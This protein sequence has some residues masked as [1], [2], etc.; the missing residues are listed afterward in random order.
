ME[1]SKKTNEDHV[2]DELSFEALEV[3]TTTL[4][5]VQ[6]PQHYGTHKKEETRSKTKKKRTVDKLSLIAFGVNTDAQILQFMDNKCF[7]CN[8][9]VCS[10]I[11]KL[12]IIMNRLQFQMEVLQVISIKNQKIAV[13]HSQ[14]HFIQSI[15]FQQQKQSTAYHLQTFSQPFQQ[16]FTAPLNLYYSQPPHLPLCAPQS[17]SL[18]FE[19]HCY[20]KQGRIV[21]QSTRFS[22]VMTHYHLSRWKTK[23]QQ[24][25]ISNVLENMLMKKIKRN[26]SA[27]FV[28]LK[29]K[30]IL[31]SCLGDAHTVQ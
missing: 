16:S 27:F 28:T 30:V 15:Q 9:C 20:P 13:P 21:E 24:Q 11:Q 25:N 8:V 2:V 10:S 17:I 22:H 19:F 18:I 14:G 23:L 29:E 5:N 4:T 3:Q 12:L 7:T 31:P 26:S 6:I 1:T